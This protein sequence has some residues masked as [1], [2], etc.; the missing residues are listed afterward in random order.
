VEQKELDALKK[1]VEKYLKGKFRGKKQFIAMISILDEYHKDKVTGKLS[2]HTHIIR[3]G[4][5]TVETPYIVVASLITGIQ[6]GI[7]DFIGKGG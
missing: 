1:D 5:I 6:K 4:N 3:V 7:E 2:L